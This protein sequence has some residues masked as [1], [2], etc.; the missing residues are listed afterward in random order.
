MP[1]T[2]TVRC[3][4]VARG[5]SAEVELWVDLKP[6]GKPAFFLV[7][8]AERLGPFRHEDEAVD[9]AEQRFGAI[10]D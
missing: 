9:L 10:F 5:T 4:A 2:E 3:I 6:D 7:A 8:T 1:I